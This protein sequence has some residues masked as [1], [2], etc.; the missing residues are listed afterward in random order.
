[1]A[2]LAAECHPGPVSP[3]DPPS[4]PR[5]P[6]L[7]PVLIATVFLTVIGAT[8]G[9]VLGIRADRRSV[10][11]GGPGSGGPGFGGAYP[12]DGDTPTDGDGRCREESQARGR[13]A[14]AVGELSARHVLRTKSSTVWICVDEAG[15]LFYHANRRS[16]GDAWIEGKTALFLTDVVAGDG[17]YEARSGDTAF[18]VYPR[19]LVIFHRDGTKEVQPAVAE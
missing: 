9:A 7:L 15:R 2:H 12:P 19:E 18:F 17:N 16:P 8:A 10:E 1:M 13:R 3:P 4:R 14:G 5:R 6:L 11:V